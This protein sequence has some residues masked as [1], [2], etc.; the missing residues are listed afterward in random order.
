MPGWGIF[1]DLMPPEVLAS[2]RAKVIRQRVTIGLSVIVV[3]VLALFA[4]SM[5]QKRSAQN[6]LN[7]AQDE[8]VQLQNSLKQYSDVITIQGTVSQ[9]Q[10]QVATLLQADID[11]P[12][13]LAS[14]QSAL[15]KTVA[16]SQMNVTIFA[17]TPGTTGGGGAVPGGTLDSGVATHIGSVTLTGVAARLTDVSAYVDALKTLPGIV[18]PFPSSNVAN[19]TGATYNI[20]ATLTSDLYTHRFDAPKTPGVN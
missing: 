4:L 20:Q 9:V 2:R 1:A 5:I 17:P 18:E 3:L 8:T 13:L 12:K 6:Q 11:F 15:P 10:T 14:L 16:I 7:T 19:G